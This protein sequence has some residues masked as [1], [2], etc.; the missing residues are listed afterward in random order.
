MP[1]P[2][3]PQ[4]EAPMEVGAESPHAFTVEDTDARGRHGGVDLPDQLKESKFQREAWTRV[5]EDYIFGRVELLEDGK[6]KRIYPTKAFLCK[7]YEINKTTV[8]SR[9]ETYDWENRRATFINHMVE[10]ATSEKNDARDAHGRNSMKIIDDAVQLFSKR[11]NDEEVAVSVTDFEKLIKLRVFMEQEILHHPEQT[12]SVGLE[13]LQRRH[14]KLREAKAA[15]TEQMGGGIAGRTE[16]ETSDAL[17]E[18]EASAQA[19]RSTDIQPGPWEPGK[20]QSDPLGEPLPDCY[21]ADTLARIV[22]SEQS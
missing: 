2:S 14:A 19:E 6:F 22:E 13:Q 5:E 8:Q 18:M 7:K 12:A 16:R 17:A 20:R 3:R 11:V 21:W 10:Q 9:A 1:K 4:T 15:E